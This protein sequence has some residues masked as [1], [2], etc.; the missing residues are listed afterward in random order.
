MTHGNVKGEWVKN[1]TEADVLSQMAKLEQQV[2]SC[3]E[4]IKRY[5][6]ELDRRK[7]VKEDPVKKHIKEGAVLAVGDYEYI[8]LTPVDSK[9]GFLVLTQELKVTYIK[10]ESVAFCGMLWFDIDLVPRKW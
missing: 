5:Q 10:P 1:I 4:K 9:G 8:A 6:E 7:Q 2:K 3:Q